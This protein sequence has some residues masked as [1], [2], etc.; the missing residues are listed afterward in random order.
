MSEEPAVIVRHYDLL[1]WLMGRVA[2]YPRDYR[3]TLG[4]RTI[5]LGLDV[6]EQ[7]LESA[8]SRSKAQSLRRADLS[9]AKLRYLVRLAKDERCVS[10]KQYEFASREMAEIGKQI[11]GWRKQAGA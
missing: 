11:G 6:L 2:K 8:Y 1:R 10:V 5:A 3:F 9:L 4:D 7:L